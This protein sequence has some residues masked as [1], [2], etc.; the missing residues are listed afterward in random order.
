MQK[1]TQDMGFDGKT[2]RWV[3]KK[4]SLFSTPVLLGLMREMRKIDTRNKTK[5]FGASQRHLS[6]YKPLIFS[7]QILIDY[8][9]LWISRFLKTVFSTQL[10]RFRDVWLVVGRRNR[11]LAKSNSDRNAGQK[12]TREEL[13]IGYC[14]SMLS[15]N[16]LMPHACT[17]FQMIT[18]LP[19]NVLTLLGRL[20]QVVSG[21]ILLILG[22]GECKNRFRTW[23]QWVP[24]TVIDQIFLLFSLSHDYAV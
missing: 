21:G 14:F 5:S 9:V 18:G 12:V 20:W 15:H 1:V 11:V 17:E 13:V 22:V 19:V 10:T 4:N 23:L 6:P 3:S 8:S 7:C 16:K 2:V 24:V